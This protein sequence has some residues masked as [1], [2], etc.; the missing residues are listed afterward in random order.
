M[1]SIQSCPEGYCHVLTTAII[2]NHSE[3][4]SKINLLPY[5]KLENSIKDSTVDTDIIELI[6]CLQNLRIENSKNL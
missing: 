1:K 2:G 6:E 4:V 3:I 5:L